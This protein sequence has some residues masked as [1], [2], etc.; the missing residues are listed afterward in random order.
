MRNNTQEVTNTESA[1]CADFSLIAA[2]A[3]VETAENFL[4]ER[5]DALANMHQQ[6]GLSK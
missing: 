6:D 3:I 4:N 5:L 1:E 2:K